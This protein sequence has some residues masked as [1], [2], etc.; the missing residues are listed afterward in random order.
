[1]D[2]LLWLSLL[3]PMYVGKPHVRM[4]PSGLNKGHK[5]RI[6]APESYYIYFMLENIAPE[7]YYK[8]HKGSKDHI[9][10]HIWSY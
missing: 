2:N 10:D 8:P 3:L 1:M 4:R 5:P 6:I 9:Y 7:S